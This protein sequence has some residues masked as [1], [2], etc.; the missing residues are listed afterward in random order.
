MTVSGVPVLSVPRAA[1][2]GILRARLLK[3]DDRPTLI[4]TPNLEMLAAARRDPVRCARLR[5]AGLCLPDGVGTL[6]L[7]GGRIRER[8]PGIEAGEYLLSVAAEEDVGVYLLGGRPGVAEAAADRLRTRFPALRIVGT[9]HGYFAPESPDEARITED[10]RR[11]SP[12]LLI[13]CTGFPRQEDY[14]VRVRSVLPGLRVGIALGGAL[15][16]W[17]GQLR[18]APELLR[19]C[20]LEWLWRVVREPKRL[21][22]LGR[23]AFRACLPQKKPESRGISP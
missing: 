13:V 22:R 19:R 4:F 11:L 14:L 2:E 16:V 9:H 6:L 17:S 5:S 20:G 21:G 10:L 23:A 15:D 1:A 8:F 18:R 3:K 12:G 7:S